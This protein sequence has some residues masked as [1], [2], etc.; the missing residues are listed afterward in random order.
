MSFQNLSIFEKTY[1]FS[2]PA[3]H[4]DH[5]RNDVKCNAKTV[6]PAWFTPSLA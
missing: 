1:A 6:S 2:H 3:L 4:P 5:I